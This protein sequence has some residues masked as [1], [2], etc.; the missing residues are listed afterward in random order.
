MTGRRRTIYN[1]DALIKG[2]TIC[3]GVDIDGSLAY[4]DVIECIEVQ[5]RPTEERR[6]NPAK[7]KCTI[8][9]GK[10]DV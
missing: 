4:Y 3:Y 9:G 1:Y 8:Q 10:K 2:E 7:L 5:S 6:G